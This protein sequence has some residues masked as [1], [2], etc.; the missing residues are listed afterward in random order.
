[1]KE[2][3]MWTITNNK[4]WTYLEQCFEWVRV[5]AETPQD[6]IHH[7]EGNVA[8]HTQMV[9]QVLEQATAYQ[10]LAP[11]EQEILWAA[12]LL[13]DVEKHSTTVIEPDGRI[14]SNGHARKGAQTARRILYTEIPA[15]FQVREQVSALVRYHGLPLWIFEKPDPIKALVKASLEV[16][17]AWLALLARADVLGRCCP[18][19]ADMLYRVDCFEELCKE[20]GCWGIA[21][22]FT[23]SHARMHYLQREDAYLE[24][25]P[26]EQPVTEVVLMSG[27]PGAGKDTFVQRNFRHWPV[28][29]LDGM[30]EQQD[31]HAT[32]KTGN[33]QVIQAAKELA[34]AYLRKQ[35][36]FV[37]N[38]T[39]T[40]RTMREQLISLFLSYGARVKIVYIESPYQQLHRQNKSREAA[41]PAVA[42]DRLV[43]K[44]EVPVLWEAHEV[45]YY[46]S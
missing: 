7:A 24:Y 36:G 12:A 35:T 2:V 1:M 17:T 5:M 4:E 3:N 28:I 44:L 13:H 8:I 15:P 19:K 33:G 20:Y 22:P 38:A 40:T 31:I 34:R 39:N 42:L 32:D 16:N 30:R 26:Y 41:I 37:W 6:P 27:L 45:E 11:Q 21:K 29:S 23:S 43:H 46:V 14:T 9:L 25:M 10:A 18:D